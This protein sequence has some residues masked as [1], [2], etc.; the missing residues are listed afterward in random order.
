MTTPNLET[1]DPLLYIQE[2]LSEWLK[3][4]SYF[5]GISV[6]TADQGNVIEALTESIG[7]TGLCVIIEPANPT[8]AY[9]GTGISI[10]CPIRIIVWEQVTMNR[11]TMGTRKRASAV[12][13][14]IVKALRPQTPSAPCTVT[15]AELTRDSG[16]ECV[17]TLTAKKKMS[18]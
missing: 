16:D 11:G 7:K 5:Q 3:A 12:A 14:E 17:Y 18:V 15:Q 2:N 6:V 10:E 1:T 9:A 13:F 8:F 4:R